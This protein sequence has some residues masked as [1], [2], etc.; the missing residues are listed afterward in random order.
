MRALLSRTPPHARRTPGFLLTG[1]DHSKPRRRDLPP[2]CAT[3]MTLHPQRRETFPQPSAR[4][5]N[6]LLRNSSRE[7]SPTRNLEMILHKW[8]PAVFTGEPLPSTKSL[9][10]S[11]RYRN[12]LP[13]VRKTEQKS[14]YRSIS[15]QTPVEA[16]FSRRTQ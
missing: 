13:L 4:P 14:P 15:V 9:T 2:R 5:M 6:S 10:L 16:L 11:K 3:P 8:R 12:P 1:T 7:K